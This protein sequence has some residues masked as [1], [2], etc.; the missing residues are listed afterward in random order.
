[1]LETGQAEDLEKLKETVEKVNPN[2]IKSFIESHLPNVLAFGVKIVL[3]LVAYFIFS[4]GIRWIRKIVKKSLSVSK[5]DDG[6]VHFIDVFL[7]TVLRFLL[8]ATI[9]VNFG[10][11]ESTIAA[12][13]GSGGLTLGLAMQGSLSNFAGGVILLVMHPFRV[14]D[15]ILENSDKNEGTVQKIELFYT[16]LITPDNKV[17]TIPNG[18]LT[19]SSVVNMT[20]MERRRFDIFVLISYDSDLRLAKETIFSILVGNDKVEKNQERDVFVEEL[21]NYGVLLCCR[22]W[23][24]MKDFW[25]CKHEITEQIKLSL[26]T[27]G[28]VIAHNQLY[29]ESKNQ[30]Q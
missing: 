25:P 6:V 9:V 16:T 30:I 4:K 19:N 1:M 5:L 21:G 12:L 27:E 24:S 28:I 3:A 22:G 20:S 14:G 23:A 7:N 15:Y 11:K 8:I 29:D 10:V 13:L 17:I 26:D 2:Y 18:S